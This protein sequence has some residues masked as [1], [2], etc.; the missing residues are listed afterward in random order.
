MKEVA[1]ADRGVLRVASFNSLV[2]MISK[3]LGIGEG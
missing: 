2:A 3:G 1:V